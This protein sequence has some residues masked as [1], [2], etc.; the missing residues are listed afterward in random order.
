MKRF[1][2]LFLSLILLCSCSSVTEDGENVNNE[3]A[4]SEFGVAFVPEAS[5]NPF[6]VK[7]KENLELFN[8]V[9]EGLFELDEKFDAVAVI[10]NQY[11]K[12]D[13]IYTITIKN[14]LSFSD[15][16]PL[17]GEDVAYSLML[18]KGEASYF[19]ARL[20]NVSAVTA[21]GN[22][23]TI[24]LVNPNAKISFSAIAI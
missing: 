7:N 21:S 1:L 10:A 15:G 14:G 16:S 8:L 20:S 24:T 17:T 6:T 19:A 2:A 4:N 22:T 5:L 13:N 9:Y 12:T 3:N 18:A 23:V 11:S